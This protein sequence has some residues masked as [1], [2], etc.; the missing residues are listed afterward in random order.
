MTK[1]ATRTS[2][3]TTTIDDDTSVPKKRIKLCTLN[4][5]I[6]CRLCAGY[7]VDATTIV[8]C[9]HTFCKSC[10]VRYLQ[11]SKYCPTCEICVHETDPLSRIK[12][13]MVMQD[14]LDKILPDIQPKERKA[15]KAFLASLHTKETEQ[16]PNADSSVR[17]TGIDLSTF[18]HHY[19]YSDH[20]N[21]C[22]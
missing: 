13:D 22:F 8:E 16:K 15:E 3:T 12:R 7:L 20:F 2:T 1:A 14:I 5:H 11:S 6:V 18:S 10:I 4:P 17:K 19:R 9:L 21:L